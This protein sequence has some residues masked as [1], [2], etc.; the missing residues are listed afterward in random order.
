[1]IP[2]NTDSIFN[3]DIKESY[4]GKSCIRNLKT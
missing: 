1:M 2:V 3:A 4:Y